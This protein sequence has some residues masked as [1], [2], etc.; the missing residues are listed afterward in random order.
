MN[1]PFI[2]TWWIDNGRMLGGQYPGDLDVKVQQRMLAALLDLGITCFVNLQEPNETG[3]GKPFR[4]YMPLVELLAAERNVRVGFRRFPISDQHVPSTSLMAD[5]LDHID[6]Q[7]AEGRRPYIHCW[8]GNGRTGTVVGCWLVRHGRSADQAFR[9]MEQGRIGREFRFPAPENS[10]QR[11]FVRAWAQHDPSLNGRSGMPHGP[12]AA[13][14]PVRPSSSTGRVTWFEKL[15]GF[16]ETSPQE[17]RKKITVDGDTMTSTV[18]GKAM[19]CGTLETPSL[20]E[21]R[22]RV[23]RIV[24]E[25]GRIELAQV[26]ANVQDLHVDPGNAGA[27]FQVASQFNL[28]E[29]VGPSITPEQG[30]GRYEDD[31]TQGPACAIAAGAGTIH[32]NYFATVNGVVGQ[33]RDNQIDCLAD[34]GKAMNNGGGRLWKMQ[35]GYALPSLEGLTEIDQQLRSM[36]EKRLDDLRGLLRIGIQWDTQ[37]TLDRCTHRISQAYCSAVPVAYSGLPANRWERFARFILEAAYEATLCVALLNAQRNGSKRVFLTLLG[38]GAFGNTSSWIMDSIE[39]AVLRHRRH[40]L[41]VA[42][43]S[44]GRANPDVVSLLQRI[45]GG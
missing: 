22:E 25:P 44:Y 33:S 34:L 30:I 8:G 15:T 18:N 1:Y 24:S 16:A 3:R 23:R 37:V 2:K 13:P 39:R 19:V 38:G 28:L 45:K 41:S 20:A 9:E 35:N 27:L 31:R 11:E 14:A 40:D 42:I 36:D 21:L 32:R 10:A 7:L 6:G 17:V 29:M 43:V 4:D 12:K 26:V 5:I